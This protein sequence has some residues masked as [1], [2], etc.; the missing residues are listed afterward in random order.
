[1]SIEVR[2]LHQHYGATRAVDGVSFD[3]RPGETLPGL[4]VP[5]QRKKESRH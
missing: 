5:C 2:E 1:M 3:L 4:G